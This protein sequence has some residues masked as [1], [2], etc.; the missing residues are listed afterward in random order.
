MIN[1]PVLSILSITWALPKE[2]SPFDKSVQILLFMPALVFWPETQQLSDLTRE[3][4]TSQP[5]TVK[6]KFCLPDPVG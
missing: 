6:T 5:E 1:Y 4:D 3:G 2:T